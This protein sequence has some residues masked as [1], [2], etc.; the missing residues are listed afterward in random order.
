L[1]PWWDMSVLLRR[2]LSDGV[3]VERALR[4]LGEENRI[5]DIV[6]RM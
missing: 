4:Y 3:V 2:A 1:K 6:I 5:Q